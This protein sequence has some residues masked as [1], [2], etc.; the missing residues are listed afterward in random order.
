M[1]DPLCRKARMQS[2][3]FQRREQD[4]WHLD[5]F[6]MLADLGERVYKAVYTVYLQLFTCLN[7]HFNHFKSYSQISDA[8]HHSSRGSPA[9]L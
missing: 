2:I 9:G 3:I 7:Y 8:K 5:A 1:V 4:E 6:S